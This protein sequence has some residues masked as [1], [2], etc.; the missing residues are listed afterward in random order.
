VLANRGHV[1]A[2]WALAAAVDRLGTV[3][4][5]TANQPGLSVISGHEPRILRR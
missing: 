4:G 5:K 2:I 1:A 3:I